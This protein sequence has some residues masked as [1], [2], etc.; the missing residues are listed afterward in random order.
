MTLQRV[1]IAALA[2]LAALMIASAANA[3]TGDAATGASEGVAATP[4]SVAP[5]TANGLPTVSVPPGGFTPDTAKGFFTQYCIACHNQYA[6]IGDMVLDTRDFEHIANDAEVWER[7]VRKLNAGAMP[8]QGMPRPERNVYESMVSWLTTS[9]DAAS[10][11]HPNPGRSSLHRLNRAE[12]G[13]AIRDLLALEVDASEFL[14][15]DDEGYGFDNIADVLR[16]SPSLLEQYLSASAKIASL[17]VGDPD[18]PAVISTFRAPPDLAQG[19][20]IE[21]LPLGTRGGVKIKH[22][23]PLDASYDFSVFL[24]R[25]IVGYMTGLEWAHELEIS[26]DGQRV[27]L[28]QVGG[29]EDNRASDENMSAAGNAI[30]ERLRTRVPVSAGPHEV[31]IAFL[32]RSRAETHEPLELHTRNLDLQDMNGLPTV[33]YAL[34]SGPHE[35]RGLGDT[36]SRD[37]IFVCRPDN[38]REE[39]PCATEILTTLARTAYRRPVT[40]EDLA[41]LL[42]FYHSG[43]ESGGFDA[44]I[45]SAIRVLLTSPDFLFRGEPDPRDAAPGSIYPVGDLALA[46]RLAFFLWSSVPDEELLSA[47][48]R[49]KL[50]DP[51]VYEA[52]VRRM[53]ADPRANA[54]VTNFAGQW[55]YLRNLESAK[56][57]VN[58]YPNFDENLRDALRRETELLFDSI[59]RED[60]SVVEL[61]T[62]DYTFVNQRLAEHYGIPNVYGSHFRRIAVHNP[63]RIGL[64]GHGSIHTVTSYPNR[65]SPVLRGKYILTNIL[66]TPPPAPP[67]NVPALEEN[68][69]GAAPKSVRARLEQHRANPVCATCHNVMDPIGFALENFDAVGAWRTQEPG[70]AVDSSGQMANG[71]PVNGPETLR[72]AL[73]AEPEHFVGIVTEKLLTYALG[74]GLEPYDM[75]TVRA[76]VR[77][78]AEHDYRFSAVVLGIANSPA[79]RTKI[80][81]DDAAGTTTASVDPARR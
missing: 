25:N 26:I 46:S 48:E 10:A 54:L 56:P 39:E 27:F 19:E 40:Q 75:P 79:F 21:G 66:G 69:P 61:L 23:F 76:I 77:E 37:K 15:A 64:L 36:P 3:Q 2:A 53:L 59:M 81:H 6:K 20:H 32:E 72:A 71:T 62:A 43:R 22:N 41:L 29:E 47:A 58:E 34:I 7:V 49:G 13:N 1:S 70:G 8:P 14:P 45:R 73:T 12:Y 80:A 55:L 5:S 24:R 52:Q 51:K 44:G 74:R 42:E 57:D 60:R 17:A 35:A 78:A 31:S 4:S 68:M 33:D 28:A 67:P 38:L 65:T 30:D 11:A 9:L 18:T 16:V 50:S 63:T